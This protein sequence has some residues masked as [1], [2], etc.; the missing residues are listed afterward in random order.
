MEF[1]LM[2]IGGAAWLIT[3]YL[4]DKKKKE[5]KAATE[6]AKQSKP[7]RKADEPRR[8]T[9]NR[10]TTRQTTQPTAA[11][12]AIEEVPVRQRRATEPRRQTVRETSARQERLQSAR[13]QRQSTRGQATVLNDVRVSHRKQQPPKRVQAVNVATDDVF[14]GKQELVRGVI[15]AEL[16][17]APKALK[18]KRRL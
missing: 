11:Q 4:D 7:I 2:I 8:R 1:L 10:S 12:V 13:G 18:G 14:I 9:T 15:M 16:L 6:A 5:R 3:M 17:A